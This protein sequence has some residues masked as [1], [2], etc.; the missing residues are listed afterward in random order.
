MGVFVRSVIRKFYSCLP[1]RAQRTAKFAIRL[2]R[3]FTVVSLLGVCTAWGK[4]VRLVARPA[5]P[6][7]PGGARYVHLGSGSINHPAF[8]NIDALPLPHVHYVGSITRLP[9]FR[10][11]TVDLLYASH[12]LEHIGYGQTREVLVEWYRVL[13]PGGVVRISVPDIDRLIE[14]YMA[15]GRDIGPVIGL[16]YGGH[17]HAYNIHRTIFNRASLENQLKDVGFRQC[18]VWTPNSDTLTTMNDFSTF[19]RVVDGVSYPVSL[20]IEATKPNAV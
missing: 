4:L 10:D 16:F 17:N 13:K 6:Q 15:C 14:I 18:R 7:N 19:S 3:D 12:C 1:S 11:A 8:I 2:V 20:N 9:M 5:F